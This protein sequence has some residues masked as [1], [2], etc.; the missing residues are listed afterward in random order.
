VEIKLMLLA[1]LVF[2]VLA[3]LAI[4]AIRWRREVVRLNQLVTEID[5]SV[6]ES[7]NSN[8]ND[9]SD[10]SMSFEFGLKMYRVNR[11]E[12]AFPIL[13]YH[14]AMRH[15]HATSLVAKMYYAGN[16]VDKSETQYIYWLERAAES[17]DKAAK[18]KLKHL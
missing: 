13:L 11:F 15:P 2:G 16:G 8:S 17:G 4:G 3:G 12:E 14:G 10:E 6:D 9:D 7:S 18:A 5:H 1:S